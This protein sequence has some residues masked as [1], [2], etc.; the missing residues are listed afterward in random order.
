VARQHQDKE[1]LAVLVVH[2]Q[3]ITP[4]AAAVVQAR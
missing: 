1:M 2:F 3:E 4:P